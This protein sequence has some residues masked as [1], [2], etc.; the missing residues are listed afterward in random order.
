MTEKQK[1]VVE[2]IERTGHLPEGIEVDDLGK[3]LEVDPIGLAVWTW[4]KFGGRGLANYAPKFQ[5]LVVGFL[6]EV[7]RWDWYDLERVADFMAKVED[8]RVIKLLYEPKFEVLEWVTGR[9]WLGLWFVIDKMNKWYVMARVGFIE[10]L[11]EF[12]KAQ[13]RQASE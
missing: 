6:E 13:R 9:E 2:H 3:W 8:P 4:G 7:S 5:D 11:K 1:M 10:Q 12:V